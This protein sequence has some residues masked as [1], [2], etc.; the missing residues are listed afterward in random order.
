MSHTILESARA[1]IDST[2]NRFISAKAGTS[3]WI[4][5]SFG[6]LATAGMV[7]FGIYAEWHSTGKEYGRGAGVIKGAAYSVPFI[8]G[9]ML[10]Y[11]LGKMSGDTA[12]QHQQGKRRSSMGNGFVDPFGNAATMRQRSRH[13]LSRGRSALG[14]EGYLF[15]N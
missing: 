2:R 6:G 9:A 3:S 1:K 4:R 13:N 8:G 10:M 14:N 11:D 7:G 12:Y 5:G 15:H